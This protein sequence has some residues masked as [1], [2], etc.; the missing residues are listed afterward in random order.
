[1]KH[2]TLALPAPYVGL[3]P[4]TEA[5]A[6]LFFGRDAHVRD[7]LSKLERRQRFLAV[8]GASGSGKSSLVRAGLIPALH[9]G[10]LHPPESR[11]VP[12]AGGATDAAAAEIPRWNVCIFN[13][14]D[15]PLANLAEALTRDPRWIDSADLEDARAALAASLS[16]S[17]LSL[18]DMYRSKAALFTGEAMLLVVDQFEEIFRYRQRNPNEV[19]R[20]VKLLLRSASDDLPIYVVITMRSDFL[21]SAVAVHGLAEAIN[22]GIYLTPRLGPEQIRS[23]ITAPLVLVGGSVDPVLATRLLNTLGGDDELPVLQHALLRMWDC[24]RRAG[25]KT[26]ETSDF[27]AVCAPPSS[28]DDG[29]E[30][31]ADEPELSQAINNHASDIYEALA[32]QQRRA[33]RQC[34]LALAE[35]SDGR[36][37]R[38]TQTMH[39]LKALVGTDLG[40]AV[41]A[42]VEAYRAQGVGFLLPAPPKVLGD[43]EMIDISHESLIRRWQRYQRWLEEE[44]LDV[45]EMKEWLQRARRQADGGGWL[46]S[47]DCGRAVN[48]RARVNQWSHASL[49]ATRYC[50]PSSYE[51]VDNYIRGSLAQLKRQ[52]AEHEALK[53]ELEEART[54]RLEIEERLQ[55]EAT[56]R[57]IADNAR[58]ESETDGVHEVPRAYIEAVE[59]AAAARDGARLEQL[60]ADAAKLRYPWSGLSLVARAQF[61]LRLFDAARKSWEALSAVNAHALEAE[62]VLGNLYERL[63][64]NA[65]GAA[66]AELLERSNQALRSALAWPKIGND[67]RG[68][69]LAQRARNLKTLWRMEWADQTDLAARR[70]RALHRMALDCFEGYREAFEVDLNGCYRGL[71]ALQMGMLLRSLANEPG[72][73]FLHDSDDDAD[74]SRASVERACGALVHVVDA[75]IRRLLAFTQGEE[76]AEERM[77]AELSRADLLFLTEPEPAGGAA[78]RRVN[79]AYRAAVPADHAFAR[80]AAVGQ[81]ALFRDLGVRAGMAQA[82]IDLLSPLAPAPAP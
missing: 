65:A 31:K 38:R 23:V 62:L 19:D 8:L 59:L 81:L 32:P 26:I 51:V 79:Q 67:A 2:I 72:W 42:V 68:E 60:A 5:E 56:E 47:N 24:A 39:E 25:R 14:G 53:R 1:V 43:D 16:I 76:R 74:A 40:G 70:E 69:A 55:R 15:A 52:N 34:F 78:S 20:F 9:R 41:E 54:G 11:A 66:K 6:L 30:L 18:A 80:E 7:L 77:W 64:R 36:G 50:G 71:A 21:G 13:P 63:S 12:Q 35:R 28:S 73:Y 33:A 48:W 3:R 57:A 49:W 27:L 58:A 10:A 61:K 44:D 82:V 37:V 29:A 17:P 45:T 75:S 46:D 4:F 22:S